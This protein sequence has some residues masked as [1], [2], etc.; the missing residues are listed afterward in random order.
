[1]GHRNR[2][3]EVLEEVLDGLT[4]WIDDVPG[5]L[6]RVGHRHRRWFLFCSQEIKGRSKFKHGSAWRRRGLLLRGGLLL[7]LD[8]AGPRRGLR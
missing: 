3:C 8:W 7:L 4:L 2:T 6:C 5:V 1:M